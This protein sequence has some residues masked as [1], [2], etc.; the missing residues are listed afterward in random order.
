[1]HLNPNV[2]GPVNAELGHLHNVHLVP[3]QDYLSFV[4]LMQRADVILTDSGGV[5]EEALRWQAGAGNARC[6]RASG[7]R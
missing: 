1:M 5:Q 6:D 4:R 2:Q 7:S 3:P